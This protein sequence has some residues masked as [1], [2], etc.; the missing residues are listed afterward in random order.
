MLLLATLA[1]FT[2]TI[3]Q[4]I[5][6]SKELICNNCNLGQCNQCHYEPVAL[7]DDP[8]YRNSTKPL[9]YF[10]ALVL[11]LTFVVGL[12]FTLH[13]HAHSIYS[14]GESDSASSV[15]VM[16]ENPGWGIM[17][18]SV[19][20]LTCTVL[21]SIIAEILIGSMDHLF[22]SNERLLGIGLFAI[23]PTVTEFCKSG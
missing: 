17:K 10:C 4:T 9:M 19:I 18:S 5:Y 3:F 11:F 20:L 13:T 15:N 1:V 23:V 14:N 6:G 12:L 16:H 8:I 2:P 21:Y 22:T 7:F